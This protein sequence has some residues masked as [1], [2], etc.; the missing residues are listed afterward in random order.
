MVIWLCIAL[1]LVGAG[2]FHALRH[3]SKCLNHHHG[4]S[5]LRR[6]KVQ[7]I[8]LQQLSSLVEDAGVF[9]APVWLVGGRVTGGTNTEEAWILAALA[10]QSTRMFE[11]GTCSGRTAYLWALNSP[12]EAEVITLTLRP[13]Q[14]DQYQASAEDELQDTVNAWNESEFTQFMYSGTEVEH[15]IRQLYGDS[16]RLDPAPYRDTCDVVFVDGSHAYSYVVNDTEKAL[17]M[18]KPG[19]LLLWHDYRGPMWTRGVYRALNELSDRLP[20]Q[21]IEGTSLVVYQKP[22]AAGAERTV[23]QAA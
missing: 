13:D 17:Q 6:W 7:S 11:F 22:L 16:K 15:K 14:L 9:Q 19:G 1:I 23:R 3:L 10:R 5:L 21:R 12:A 4:R 20:I 2:W 18:L 8:E